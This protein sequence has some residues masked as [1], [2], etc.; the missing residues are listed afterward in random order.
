MGGC[1]LCCI[2]AIDS[3]SVGDSLMATLESHINRIL[4]EANECLTAVEITL[5]LNADFSGRAYP[6]RIGEIVTC[7]DRMLNLR[8]DGKKYCF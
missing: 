8:K 3:K 7:A 2:L 5:R 4:I 1:A 6:Y